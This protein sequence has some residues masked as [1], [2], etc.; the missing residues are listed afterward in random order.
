MQTELWPR[1]PPINELNAMLDELGEYEDTLGEG[2]DSCLQHLR[3]IE[4]LLDKSVLPDLEQQRETIKLAWE[5]ALDDAD[6]FKQQYHQ[7]SEHIRNIKLW[8]ASTDEEKW[9]PLAP[10][11][12][13]M[14]LIQSL[15]ERAEKNTDEDQTETA[16]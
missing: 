6:L 16:E 12:R 9:T 5:S 1:T 11:H 15:V 4:Q 3:E 2:F 7:I 10:A 14:D 8:M 13:L